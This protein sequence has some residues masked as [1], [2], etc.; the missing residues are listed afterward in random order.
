MK[1]VYSSVV[2]QLFV[3]H[4]TS[5]LAPTRKHPFPFSLRVFSIAPKRPQVLHPL[6]S[7]FCPNP[8]VARDQ[9]HQKNQHL[10]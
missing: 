2:V 7:A 5:C 4:Y 3:G 6:Q 9:D 1:I 10:H 8:D